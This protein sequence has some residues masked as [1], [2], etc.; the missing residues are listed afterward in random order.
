MCFIVCGK[1]NQSVQSFKREAIYKQNCC[2][3][4]SIEI[5]RNCYSIQMCN[6][7]QKS[8]NWGHF[9]L[10][11]L[12][13]SWRLLTTRKFPLKTLNPH[14]WLSP[15]LACCCLNDSC[16]VLYFSHCSLK[17]SNYQIRMHNCLEI[18]SKWT[19]Q[20]S[21]L[22]NAEEEKFQDDEGLIVPNWPQTV[23]LKAF[24]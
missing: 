17:S 6:G 18:I 11:L 7:L 21:N 2:L 1:K 13:K 20:I 12:I 5:W 10:V 24:V 9:V 8:G 16:R 15:G 14:I 22:Y 23:Q 4:K 19:F 3:E